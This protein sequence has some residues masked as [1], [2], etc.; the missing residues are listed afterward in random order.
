[1]KLIFSRAELGKF[2]TRCV[3]RV[4]G[5]RRSLVFGHS[6]DGPGKELSLGSEVMQFLVFE[7]KFHIESNCGRWRDAKS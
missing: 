6:R 1:M 3:G 2:G 4:E 5:G 7:L